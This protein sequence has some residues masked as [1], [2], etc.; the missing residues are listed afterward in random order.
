MTYDFNGVVTRY[1]G[2]HFRSVYAIEG[3]IQRWNYWSGC[4][5]DHVGSLFLALALRTLVHANLL[6]EFANSFIV[7]A[8][9]SKKLKILLDDSWIA[10]KFSANRAKR[11]QTSTILNRE[12][13]S[14]VIL[15][16][17]LSSE[18]KPRKIKT[19]YFRVS[20][21]ISACQKWYRG[22]ILAYRFHEIIM[23]SGNSLENLLCFKAV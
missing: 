12:G 22:D 11:F 7:I 13:R 20:H 16:K 14:A 17:E 5:E 1:L 4:P 21:R 15:K 10:M 23:G 2:K 6:R 19:N 3:G 9:P 8:S 18:S